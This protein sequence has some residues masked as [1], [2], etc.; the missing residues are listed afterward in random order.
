MHAGRGRFLRDEWI[1]Q[2][3]RCP[4]GDIDATVVDGGVD[5]SAKPVRLADVVIAAPGGGDT[6]KA[7]D[8]VQ[9][10]G[11]SQGS[12]DVYSIGYMPNVNDSIT[13]AW[14]NGELDNGAG[15]DFAVFENPF[16]VGSGMFMDLVIVEVS[17]DGTN[18]RAIDHEYMNTNQTVYV[19]NPALWRGFAGR[20]PVLLKS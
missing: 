19:N 16:A 5:A 14:S 10:G 18:W 4:S 13:L 8:G 7:V 11:T 1:V 9:G 15:D 12:L 3:C 2:S 6:S 17:R 20:T